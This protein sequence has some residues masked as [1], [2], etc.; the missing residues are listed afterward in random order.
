[1]PSIGRNISKLAAM[2]AANAAANAFTLPLGASSY[3]D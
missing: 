3:D 2:F 1:M